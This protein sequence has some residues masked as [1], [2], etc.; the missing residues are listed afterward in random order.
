MGIL[1]WDKPA[2]IRTADE[3][4]RLHSADGAPPGTYVPNMTAA[5]QNKWKAK[6]VGKTT[7]SPQVEIRKSVRGVQMLIIVSL[8]GGIKVGNRDRERSKGVNVQM[9][10]NGPAQMTFDEMAAL[11]AAVA[12][13]RQVLET[14]AQSARTTS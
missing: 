4:A 9:S 3:H 11:Q 5:D 12:E 13:A 10:M 6:L 1:S 8:G 7:G 14:E 2:R